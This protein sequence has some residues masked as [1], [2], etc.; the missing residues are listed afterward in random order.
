MGPKAFTGSRVTGHVSFNRG[1]Q[2][3]GFCKERSM[4]DLSKARASLPIVYGALSL[5]VFLGCA[6][7]RCLRGYL[8]GLSQNSK[9]PFGE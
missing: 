1:P 4:V 9:L 8:F 2:M 3:R 7:A 5:L 6:K